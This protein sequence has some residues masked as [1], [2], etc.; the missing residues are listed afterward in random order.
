MEKLTKK[1]KK[2]RLSGASAL[3]QN[4]A[5]DRAIKTLFTMDKIILIH[6]AHRCPDDELSS[7]LW[8]MVTKYTVWIYKRVPYMKYGISAIEIYSRSRFDM[9]SE[10]LSNCYVWGFNIYVLEPKLQNH[11]VKIPK[12]D[13]RIQIGVNMGLTKIY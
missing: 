8:P 7:A 6:A 9:V 2:I 10:T 3:H 11:G 5:A 4:E 12:W 1:Q 13:P